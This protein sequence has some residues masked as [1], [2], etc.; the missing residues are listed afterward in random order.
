VGGPPSPGREQRLRWQRQNRHQMHREQ[1]S[2]S[3]PILRLRRR[4]VVV[5]FIF[6]FVQ[7]VE[8][9]PRSSQLGTCEVFTAKIPSLLSVVAVAPYSHLAIACET[10]GA[11]RPI[12][13]LRSAQPGS[14]LSVSLQEHQGS[15]FVF[16]A[17][18]PLLAN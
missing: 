6:I 5:G 15:G 9:F 2:F 11:M 16:L 12:A 13:A 1:R 10:D 8:R 4:K 3:L 14:V 17:C 18:L 7:R